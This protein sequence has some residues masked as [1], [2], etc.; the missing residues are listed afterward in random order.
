MTRLAPARHRLRLLASV[1]ALT[2]AACGGGGGAQEG[3]G[4]G[5]TPAPTDAPAVD[6]Q[7]PVDPATVDTAATGSTGVDTSAAT[8]TTVAPETEFAP[9]VFTTQSAG[10]LSVS[11]SGCVVDGIASEGAESWESVALSATHAFIPVDG[12][13]AA[14]AFTPGAA[15]VATLDA[16]VGDG[17]I[18]ATPDSVDTVSATATNKVA[19]SGVF[20]TTVFDVALGQSFTCDD[21]TGVAAISPDGARIVTTFPGSPVEQFDL[22]DTTCTAAGEIPLPADLADLYFFGFAGSDYY[23]GGKGTDETVYATL[24]SGGATLWKVGNPEV[25]AQGWIGWVHGMVPCNGGHCIVDTNTDSLIVTDAAGVVR[26]QFPISELIG[27]RRFYHEMHVGPDGAVYLVTS[28]R[29]D[30]GAGGSKYR[31]DLVRLEITG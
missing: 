3:A 4:E 11:A 5:S 8:E 10:P 17:G 28:E 12:G 27:G 9:L 23:M 1:A 13:V 20:S 30:D 6:S 18:L 22:S 14:L 2:L 24:V 15:C 7:V 31:S 16:T 29:G 26:A 19:A 25:G 21:A